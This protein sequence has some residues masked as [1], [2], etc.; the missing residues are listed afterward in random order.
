MMLEL[1]NICKDYV[2]GKMVVPVLR[3]VQFSMDE[4]NTLRSCGP[5]GSGKT[6]T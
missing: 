3:D 6:A 5:S 1:K 4:E 2:Q